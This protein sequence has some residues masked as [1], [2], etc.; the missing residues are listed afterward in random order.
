MWEYL[1]A[2]QEQ[3]GYCR[4]NGEMVCWIPGGGGRGNGRTTAVLSD[5]SAGTW[6]MGALQ[7]QKSKEGVSEGGQKR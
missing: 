4:G 7:S 5:I 3:K 1:R 2:N 6:G